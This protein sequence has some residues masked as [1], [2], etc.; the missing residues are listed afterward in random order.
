MGETYFMNDR[1]QYER[2]VNYE[3]T[4][5]RCVMRIRNLGENDNGLWECTL[6]LINPDTK[7]TSTMMKK[8]EIKLAGKY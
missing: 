8:F 4:D 1:E 3:R 7:I 5:N 2:I 6:G